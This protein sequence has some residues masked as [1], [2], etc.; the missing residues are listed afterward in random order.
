MGER[1]NRRGQNAGFL[2][3]EPGDTQSY[4]LKGAK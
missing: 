1:K 4:R 2:D 3:V